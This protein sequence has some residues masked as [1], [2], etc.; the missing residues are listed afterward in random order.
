MMTRLVDGRYARAPARPD[1]CGLWLPHA[2]RTVKSGI[3]YNTKDSSFEIIE[4]S[5][6]FAVPCN[7]GVRASV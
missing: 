1:A 3:H 6:V 7:P 5:L 4:L 2:L